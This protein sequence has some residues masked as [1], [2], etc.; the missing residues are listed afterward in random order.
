MITVPS[1]S[2][3]S[4]SWISFLRTLSSG[5]IKISSTSALSAPFRS[6]SLSNFPPR[7]RFTLPISR[8]FPA[9]VSPVR[10]FSPLPNSTSVSSISARFFTCKLCSISFSPLA[11]AIQ[12]LLPPSLPFFVFLPPISPLPPPNVPQQKLYHPLRYIPP[13]LAIPWHPALRLRPS[14]YPAPS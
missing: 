3:S 6:I 1:S 14:P 2:G 8:D 11:S 9:P 13:L 12:H 4:S 10:I 7:A 5:L